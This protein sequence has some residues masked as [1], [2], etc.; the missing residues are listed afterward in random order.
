VPDGDNICRLMVFSVYFFSGL[1]RLNGGFAGDAFPWL[2]EP[3]KIVRHSVGAVV[4]FRKAGLAPALLYQHTRRAAVLLA[5][6]M[7]AAI[8]RAIGPLGHNY[9]TV[10]WPWNVVM[11]ASVFSSSGA[12]ASFGPSEVGCRVWYWCSSR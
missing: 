3:F 1:Q 8:L 11:A 2:V 4:P 9:T 12:T 7:H 6:C 10:V 5:I